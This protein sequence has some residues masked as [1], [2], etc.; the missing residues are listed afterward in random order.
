MRLADDLAF[1]AGRDPGVRTPGA[2]RALRGDDE[3]VAIAAIHALAEIG[4]GEAGRML[5]GLSD[6]RAFV[7]EHA[8]WALG[9]GLPRADGMGALL[10]MVVAGDSAACSRSARSSGGRRATA[11]Q[12]AVGVEGAL[13][14][15]AAPEARARLVETLGLVRHPIA[16]ARSC[17]W[18]ATPTRPTV[19]RV[20]AARRSVSAR[21][22]N[23]GRPLETAWPSAMTSSATSPD[24]R[25][26]TWGRRAA[27]SPH[28][29]TG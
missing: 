18:R 21:R 4:D 3:L 16:T 5:V 9:S 25:W 8:A 20:A 17:G 23:G 14:G 27:R 11:E 29:R 13:L 22:M 28:E 24:S 26:S 2:R 19:V 10:G 6:D 15:V 7:R 1:E 12:L